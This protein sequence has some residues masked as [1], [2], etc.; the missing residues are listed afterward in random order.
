MQTLKFFLVYN[1]KQ[2][3]IFAYFL[4]ILYIFLFV[5]RP[6]FPYI[7]RATQL[8]PRQFLNFP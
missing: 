7:F 6:L 1:P 3:I 8:I 5:Y 4:C 2:I